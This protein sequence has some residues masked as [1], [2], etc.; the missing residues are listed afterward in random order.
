[1][2]LMDRYVEVTLKVDKIIDQ[3]EDLAKTIAD[4]EY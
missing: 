1:V 3:I 2:A 4:E